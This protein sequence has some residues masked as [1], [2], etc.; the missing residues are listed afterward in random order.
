MKNSLISALG[1]LLCTVFLT[2]CSSPGPQ[3]ASNP[4]I[5]R[6]LE[7]GSRYYHAG[8]L[9]EAHTAFDAAVATAEQ[10]DQSAPLVDAWMAKGATELLQENHLGARAS[11]TRAL[12]EAQ[13]AKLPPRAWQAQI[14]LA[15][16]DRRQGLPTQARASL[17]QLR[18]ALAAGSADLFKLDQ[19]LALCA[20]ADKDPAQS[21]ALLQPWMAR[22]ADLPPD[23]RAVLLANMAGVQL[24]R[25]QTDSALALAQDALTLDRQLEHPPA[26]AA[27]HLL[28]AR[29]LQRMDLEAQA[30]AHQ[31]KAQRIRLSIGLSDMPAVAP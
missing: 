2:A 24:E 25:G 31:G 26:I 4:A 5:S 30:L 17:A 9:R 1:L 29:V 19:S 10:L 16:L 14:A 7:D 28:L 27:D 11:Y 3:L 23:M 18:P 6:H 20:L 8:R 21:M 13:W 15:D 12:Q 22:M